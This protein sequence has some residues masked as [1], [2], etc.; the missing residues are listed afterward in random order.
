MGSRE[1][2]TFLLPV[3]LG[4]E[5]SSLSYKEGIHVGILLPECSGD[6]I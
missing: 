4:R 1:S 2:L 3:F 6:A 5:L